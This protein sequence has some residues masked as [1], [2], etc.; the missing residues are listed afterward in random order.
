MTARPEHPHEMRFPGESLEYRHARDALL[1]A[2][3]DV[4]DR[5]E[6]VARQRRQLPLGGVAP[7]DYEFQE[8]DTGTGTRRAVRLSELFA[9]GKDTLFIYS[10]MFI[11]GP[12]GN[13]IGSPCPN[14][15]SII[16]AVAGQAVHL[17]QRINLAV[18][19]KASIEQ[20]RAHAHSRRWADVRL[21][22]SAGSAFNVDY[23]AEDAE[24]RQW[25]IAH[26]S[27]AGMASSTTG[28]ALSCS[29]AL[30]GRARSHATSTSCGLTGTSSTARPMVARRRT[31]LACST[32]DPGGTPQFCSR[33]GARRLA[34]G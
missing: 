21:L 3:K 13:P 16:D 18:S 25:P 30:T 6:E 27:S 31:R 20:F 9:D 2:E 1:R 17:T 33:A 28:G 5:T 19:A 23:G 34:W 26:V 24:G 8:W 29:G 4:R 22:S 15:T 14:C 12:D 7:R 10:F 11:E 32:R